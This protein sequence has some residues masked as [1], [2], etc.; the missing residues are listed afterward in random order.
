MSHFIENLMT[1]KRSYAN[2]INSLYTLFHKDTYVLT[3]YGNVSLYDYMNDDNIF[4]QWKFRGTFTSIDEMTRDNGVD[5]VFDMVDEMPSCCDLDDYILVAEFMINVAEYL[6][7]CC[8]LVYINAIFDNIYQAADKYNLKVVQK[9]NSEIIL[10][11]KEVM[12]DLAADSL[13]NKS[14]SELL[15]EYGRQKNQGDVG[16]K[17]NII[18]QLFKGFF[19]PNRQ[20]IKNLNKDLEKM[21]GILSGCARHDD[22]SNVDYKDMSKKDKIK[23]L[24]IIFDLYTEAIILFKLKDTKAT[25]EQFIN[26]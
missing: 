7:G 26:N 14:L 17:E 20:S 3:E 8:K 16:V 9:E 24:D 25:A 5:N 1:K 22:N 19:E 15:Y 2:E 12:V 6:K 13:D 11:N 18:A 21:I 10:T 23:V 4:L